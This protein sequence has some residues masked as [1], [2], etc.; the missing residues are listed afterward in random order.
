MK[1]GLRWAVIL[2]LW[3]RPL[4]PQEQV[5]SVDGI[6]AVVG[7]HIVLKS[8]VAQ[9]TSLAT[10]QRGLDPTR[11]GDAVA[12]L[13]GEVL[14]AMI[15][16]KIILE[17]AALDSVEVEEKDVERALDQQIDNFIAQAGSEEQAEKYLGQ[18]LKAFRRE[19]WFEMRDRLVSEKYQQELISSVTVNRQ[20][21]IDFF[22]T[23]RDSLLPFPT[24]VKLRHLQISIQ[25][26][27]ESVSRALDTIDSIRTRILAGESFEELARRY[28]Q[29]PG[30]GPQGG[31]LGFVRRGALVPEFEQVAFTLKPGQISSPVKTT[32][33]YHLI[34]TLEKRGDRIHPRHILI[35]PQVAARDDSLAWT[36]AA[37]LKDSATSLEAFERLVK[38]HSTDD[39]TRETGG[40]LGWI[41]PKTYKP[42][43]IGAA[44]KQLETGVCGGP[45]RTSLG[46]HLLWPEAVRPGGSP[47][48]EDHWPEVEA[49][50]LNRKRMLW[51]QDWIEFARSNFFVSVTQ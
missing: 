46:Y 43:E 40:D 25:A 14:Q 34:E 15:D 2:I 5:P 41:D 28:S 4:L 37:A 50:A 38:N 18:S 45:A 3:A 1:A 10:L 33:G 47:S 20:G 30:S 24:L 21:V 29:D 16:Q 9:Q 35:T 48:L 17:M 12:R 49:M 23:Y 7:D 32:F 31:S 19:F 22:T 36:R 42:L 44:L 39:K 13:Q 27:P 11:D 6:A 51:Y 8:E 26:G